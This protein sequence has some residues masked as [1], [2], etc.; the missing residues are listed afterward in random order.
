MC[1]QY[2]PLQ[3]LC[4]QGSVQTTEACCVWEKERQSYGVYI[5]NSTIRHME[6]LGT[7][8]FSKGIQEAPAKGVR[9]LIA[10]GLLLRSL[11]PCCLEE[12]QC[13]RQLGLV[14]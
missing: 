3:L 5:E 13:G 11:L 10:S 8:T 2:N 9:E 14:D 12:I 6:G 4:D 7:N 1:V